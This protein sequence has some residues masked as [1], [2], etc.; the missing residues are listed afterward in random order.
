MITEPHEN[1]I[2]IFLLRQLQNVDIFRFVK[3]GSQLDVQWLTDIKDYD[4]PD[5]YNHY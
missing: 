5:I 2:L 3:P 4:S 1:T